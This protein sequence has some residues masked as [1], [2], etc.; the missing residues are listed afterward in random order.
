MLYLCLCID[1]R[2]MKKITNITDT[3]RYIGTDDADLD[4]FESQYAVPNGISYNSYLIVDEQVAIMDTVDRRRADAWWGNLV[5]ALDGRT[6]DYLIVQHMEPDHAACIVQAVKCYPEMRLV[7]SARAVQMMSQFFGEADWAERT[8][9]VKEGDTLLLGRH[10]LQFMMAPMVHWPEVMVAYERM[11]RTLFSADAFG[12]FGTLDGEVMDRSES[13]VWPDE[14]RRYYYNICGKYAAP[15]QALL[16]KVAQQEVVRICPLHGP[17]LTCGLERYVDLYDRWSR[18]EA[19]SN[20]VLI[21]YA[22]I[23][24][25]TAKAARCM[26]DMLRAKGATE[27]R[28]LELSRIDMSVAVTEAFR[29]GRMVLAASSYD[30]SV[31][32]PMFD[33]LHHLQLKGYQ[34][35][36]VGMIENG[37]WAPSAGRVM[38]E[39]MLPMK[40]IDMVAPMVTIRS[41]LH[42]TDMQAMEALAEAMM[43]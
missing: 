9:V 41:T 21:A 24:G 11:T 4:L 22:S 37:S 23:H 42:P 13:R 35:R 6:P 27:V 26:A 1:Q 7:A 3:I 15:V 33:F 36:R 43:A 8:V 40:N 28:V 25:G 20:G 14:A 32:P 34:K 31:F 30:L 18:Y 2:M 5:A 38:K 10:T 17:I 19:E 16:K 29:F 12:T 39:L